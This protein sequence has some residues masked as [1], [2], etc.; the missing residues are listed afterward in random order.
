MAALRRRSIDNLRRIH[1]MHSQLA[2]DSVAVTPSTSRSRKAT[3]DRIG[4]MCMYT[5]AHNT[6]TRTHAH[7]HTHTH[8]HTH[9]RAHAHTHPYS[10]SGVPITWM[11]ALKKSE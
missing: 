5:H 6:H 8:T 2:P 11:K 1:T 10:K 4:T 9:A 7:T 3:Q